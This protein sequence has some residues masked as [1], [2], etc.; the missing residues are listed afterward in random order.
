MQISTVTLSHKFIREHV[1]PGDF[2]IDATAGRGRDTVL[3]R[4]LAGETG[5]VLAFDIQQEALDSTGALLE[6]AGFPGGAALI[7][8]SHADMDRYAAPGTVDCI[9]FNFGWLPGGD[10]LVHTRADSSV[11]AIGKGLLLLRQGG[12]M[13]L[14]LYYGRDNGY[15]ERDAILAFLE[16]LEPSEYTVLVGSFLNR[17]GDVPIPVFIVKQG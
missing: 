11:E 2:C 4:K 13:S 8:S 9:V 14:S 17:R 5:R 16:S 15:G 6:E 7:L 1:K 12:I 3:L 10:H